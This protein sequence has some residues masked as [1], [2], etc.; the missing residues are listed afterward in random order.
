MDQQIKFTFECRVWVK[1]FEDEICF[2]TCIPE[3]NNIINNK[4][5]YIIIIIIIKS[6]L[7]RE[8]FREIELFFISYKKILGLLGKL[9]LHHP[10]YD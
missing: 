2:T 10:Y 3:L 6:T 8:R 7:V 5:N 4:C 1:G 9:D